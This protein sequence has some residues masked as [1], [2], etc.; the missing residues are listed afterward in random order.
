MKL[1]QALIIAGIFT[2]TG[3]TDSDASGIVAIPTSTI[4]KLDHQVSDEAKKDL[5]PMPIVDKEKEAK[6][7]EELNEPTADYIGAD[8]ITEEELIQMEQRQI[9]VEHVGHLDEEIDW[10]QEPD[11]N[12]DYRKER[13]KACT[14][15]N[16][17]QESI[18]ACMGE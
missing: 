12:V 6:W 5:L 8:E 11:D 7:K 1:F 18:D 16:D 14:K 17:D 9:R 2:A 10:S 4:N 15:Y 13:L 3:C